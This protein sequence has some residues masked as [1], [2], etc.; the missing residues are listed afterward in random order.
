M[1]PPDHVTCPV[2]DL[3]LSGKGED[4]GFEGG[5]YSPCAHNA[6]TA[7]NKRGANLAG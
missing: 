3:F 6:G 4:T 5:V 1:P 2:L 7:E